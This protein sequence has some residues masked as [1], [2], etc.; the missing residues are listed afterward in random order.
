VP[1]AT[2]GVF[3]ANLE[4][5]D[6]LAEVVAII[7]NLRRDTTDGAVRHRGQPAVGYGSGALFLALV[8]LP[9]VG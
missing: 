6:Q 4:H 7:A 1:L 3:P 8:M 2:T 5:P 9:W